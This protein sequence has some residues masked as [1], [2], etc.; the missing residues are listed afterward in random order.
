MIESPKMDGVMK[1]I[2]IS[3]KKNSPSRSAATLA[4]LMRSV[5]V[6][7]MQIVTPTEFMSMKFQYQ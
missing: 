6:T 5:L 3:Y 7:M 2:K 4:D 1:T